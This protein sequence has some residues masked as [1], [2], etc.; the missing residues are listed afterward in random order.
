MCLQM[1]NHQFLIMPILMT[2]LNMAVRF[3]NVYTVH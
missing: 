1:L 3:N 2:V